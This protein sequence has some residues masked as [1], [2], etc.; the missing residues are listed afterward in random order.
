MGRL[1][2]SLQIRGGDLFGYM[3]VWMGFSEE[4]TRFFAAQIVLVRCQSAKL[5]LDE[6]CPQV[7]E[8]LHFFNIVYRDLKPVSGRS[9]L[10]LT[11]LSIR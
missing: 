7:F 8:Y 5:I 3:K 1:H 9:T 10:C 4:I 11:D 6:L 2:L